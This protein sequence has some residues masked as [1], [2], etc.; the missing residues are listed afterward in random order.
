MTLRTEEITTSSF[1]RVAINKQFITVRKE[2]VK[3]Q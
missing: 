2:R 1:K 3:K